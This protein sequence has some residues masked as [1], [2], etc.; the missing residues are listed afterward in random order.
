MPAENKPSSPLQITNVLRTRKS[1]AIN[2]TVGDGKFD[3]DERDNPLPSFGQAFDALPPIVCR[4]LGLPETYVE[5]L[6]VI[7]VKMSEQ[8]AAPMVSFNVRKGLPDAAKEF[9]FV[10]PPRLLA[11]PTEPGSYT[12]PLSDADA[13]AVWEAIEQ[14]KRYVLKDR[15][16]G[17]I[18]FED[19]D[20]EVEVDADD[21]T[22]DL[23]LD[24][25]A[26]A[27]AAAAE[28]AKPK[29][30]RAKKARVAA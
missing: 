5:N 4:V 12:P 28:E 19:D 15:A 3:L 8:G 11:H 29:K 30:Q 24:E 25:E 23:P 6:R 1:V 14:A 20:G 27:P 22:A 17:Q 18:A 9:A 13:A 2:W 7:G 26:E 21:A 10:T 16:Q